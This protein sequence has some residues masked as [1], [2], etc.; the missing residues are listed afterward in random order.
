LGF[1]QLEY[2]GEPV[3]YSGHLFVNP[4]YSYNVGGYPRRD[5]YWEALERER[6]ALLQMQWQQ[7]E[8]QILDGKDSVIVDGKRIDLISTKEEEYDMSFNTAQCASS[9]P[10]AT[11]KTPGAQLAEALGYR[12]EDNQLRTNTQYHPMLPYEQQLVPVDVN[13]FNMLRMQ[14]VDL[15]A[16]LDAIRETLGIV[17]EKNSGYTA[18]Q[19]STDKQV[20]GDDAPFLVG[21]IR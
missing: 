12:V 4:E 14:V 5:Y 6:T 18:S 20:D 10:P 7:L 11:N 15:S 9:A 3:T 21:I 8:S 17:L 2:N 19:T 16:Q 13:A 1:E